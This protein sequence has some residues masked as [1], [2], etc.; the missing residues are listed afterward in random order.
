LKVSPSDILEDYP[1]IK[2]NGY[3]FSDGCGMICEEFAGRIARMLSNLLPKYSTN[4]N[5]GEYIPS[6]FQVRQ[7]RDL[8]YNNITLDSYWWTQRSGSCPQN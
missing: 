7:D 4:S 6:V 2:Y 8:I 1:D 5:K 3:N